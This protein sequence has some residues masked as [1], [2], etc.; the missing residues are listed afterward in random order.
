MLHSLKD[1][2]NAQ[3]NALSAGPLRPTIF[4]SSCDARSAASSRSTPTVFL[5]A[6]RQYANHVRDWPLQARPLHP[7][8]NTASRSIQST[9]VV[10]CLRT[11]TLV[12]RGLQSQQI[13]EN[14]N[15][16]LPAH[17]GEETR[18]KPTE[19]RQRLRAS[20]AS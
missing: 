12:R 18:G 1:R 5:V 13:I 20:D 11:L 3:A 2:A 10:S 7:R 6:N 16:G 17:C 14:H 9:R 19:G 4:Q 15:Q 8:A